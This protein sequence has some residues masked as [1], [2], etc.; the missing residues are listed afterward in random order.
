MKKINTL[1][2]SAALAALTWLPSC[3]TLHIGERIRSAE[4]LHLG[5]A[6]EHATEKL[7]HPK[8]RKDLRD[9]FFVSPRYVRAPEVSY[10]T[11]RPILDVGGVRTPQDITPTGR[12]VYIGSGERQCV[13][14]EAVK[15]Y[16]RVP[17]P[18][19]DKD[20]ASTYTDAEQLGDL[21]TPRMTEA[22]LGARIA[23]APF[24]Y[25]IDPLYTGVNYGVAYTALGCAMV[26]A[27]PIWFGYWL[28]DRDAL[29]PWAVFNH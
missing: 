12:M 11:R 25:L 6:R 7:Y 19:N 28:Y 10:R 8:D 27:T 20:F 26:V 17:Q 29:P 2:A 4:E 21:E 14:E 24:D 9:G 16:I 1:F 18:E 22:S 13:T 15:G 23:A 5:V 3:G